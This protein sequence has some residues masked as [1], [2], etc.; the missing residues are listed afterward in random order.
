M[1]PDPLDDLLKAYS[2]QPLPLPPLQSKATIWR[3]IEQRRRRRT[4]F[5]IFPVRSWREL[6][7]E[8]RLA[9]AGLAIALVT[10]IV[11]A[12]AAHSFGETP[13]VVRESLHLDVFT[14]CPSCLTA[15]FL[16]DH[17]RR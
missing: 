14:T 7:A 11:P 2:E 3:E 13:R 8:P 10:G 17:R 4:W 6:F 16:S 15:N 5:G 1:N 12:A 9:I